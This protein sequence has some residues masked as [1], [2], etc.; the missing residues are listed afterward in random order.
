MK[1]PNRFIKAGSELIKGN[2]GNS[3]KSL[4][5][6][7]LIESGSYRGDGG[8]FFT[9]Q[10]G[11][12]HYFSYNSS[13]DVVRAY[14][15][16]PP[17]A[18]IINRLTQAYMAGNT[19]ITNS[20]GKAKGKEAE[21]LYANKLRNLMNKPNLLQNWQEF[22]AQGKVYQ[23]LYG[24][25]VI[26]IVKSAGFGNIEASALWNIPPA[27]L[28]IK[29][30]RVNF[31]DKGVKSLIE[32]IH[33][34]Y[35]GKRTQLD[36]DNIFIMKDYIPSFDTIVF[37]ESRIRALEM[38]I[39]NIIGAY[40]SRNVLINRRGAMGILSSEK[41]DD[42]GLV[43]M[44][45]DEKKDLERDFMRYG[46]LK[47]QW[48][49]ILSQA[50]VKWQNIGFAT[51]DLLLFEEIQDDTQRICD[52][53][54]YQYELVA[55]NSGVSYANLKE[56]KKLL[57]QDTIIPESQSDY[58]QWNQLFNTAN[59]NL[60]ITKNYDHVPVLQE[61]EEK[62][63]KARLN[64][65]QALFIEFKCN[66]I[67]LNRWRELNGEEPTADGNIYY[68]ELRQV[69]GDVGTVTTS[70]NDSNNDSNNS[71]NSNNGNQ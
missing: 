66:A 31:F 56:A 65:N 42:S 47:N 25:N 46:L 21:G 53:Y 61:D 23:K 7:E 54:G 55:S 24:Y 71:N 45:P 8:F 39:N 43:S 69:I 36:L 34:S 16:C 51:K 1:S 5:G 19:I 3:V 64:R 59:Y 9:T 58:E 38:P 52:A 26:L 62:K 13:K 57:Y 11:K 67:T 48:Q 33:I 20:S 12:E 35:K 15:K 28:E 49:F 37:P 63:A 50:P 6:S 18:S 44:T 29:E 2:I 14:T 10:D 27:I 68:S 70:N 4:F 60:E 22:E 40:E 32:S 30:S 41:S 17:L